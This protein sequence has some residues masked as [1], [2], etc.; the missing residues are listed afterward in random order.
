MPLRSLLGRCPASV[1]DSVTLV[2][3]C[4][5]PLRQ[6]TTAAGRQPNFPI[7]PLMFSA[8]VAEKRTVG[9]FPQKLLSWRVLYAVVC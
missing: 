2:L 3:G 1:R 6:V 8:G 7:Y 4:D 9:G 5:P